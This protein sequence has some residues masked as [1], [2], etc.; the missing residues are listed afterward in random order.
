MADDYRPTEPVQVY[1]PHAQTPPPAADDEAPPER[2][3]KEN[4]LLWI[5][6][7]VLVF[8]AVPLFANFS[9]RAPRAAAKPASAPVVAVE[10]PAEDTAPPAPPEARQVLDRPAPLP[11]RAPVDPTRQTVTKC[12]DRGRVVYTQTGECS[13]SVSAVPIDAGKN[14]VGPTRDASRP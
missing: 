14:V 5:G 4:P 13:G 11:A 7:V 10:P 3:W 1:E 9:A 12:V 2:T 8:M 6:V